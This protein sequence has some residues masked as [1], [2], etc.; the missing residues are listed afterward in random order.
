MQAC[1]YLYE[2]MT[3][4][5]QMMPVDRQ[6]TL[7]NDITAYIPAFCIIPPVPSPWQLCSISCSNMAVLPLPDGPMMAT[8]RLISTGLHSSSS[9]DLKNQSLPINT[10]HSSWCTTSNCRGFSTNSDGE[11]EASLA[12]NT[13]SR[14]IMTHPGC[15][16]HCTSEQTK[17]SMKRITSGEY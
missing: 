12:T 4:K 6:T 5:Y 9:R 7:T 16:F 13:I 11:S 15:G 1:L 10:G 3:V 17:W 2:K 8:P 14:V